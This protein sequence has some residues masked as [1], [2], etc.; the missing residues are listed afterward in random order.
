MPEK[1]GALYDV[2]VDFNKMVD[3][4]N[5][6]VLLQNNFAS[7][8]WHEF[9]TPIVSIKGYAELLK[10]NEN[11]SKEEYDK[12]INIIIEETRRLSNLTQST[13]LISKLDTLNHFEETAP[14]KIN[15][16]IEECVIL[17]DG[18]FQEKNID[19]E[20]SLTPYV[21]SANADTFKNL[22]INL[23][24]NAI[25]YNK[26]NGKIIVKSFIDDDRYVITF[27]DTGIGM[28]KKTLS[29][30]FDKYYQGD[31]S[32]LKKG[33]GLGLPIAKR[34]VELAGGYMFASSEV[35][36]GTTFTIFFP[37]NK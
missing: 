27:E 20:L 18:S 11:L 36:V 33:N 10:N 21:I 7:N 6:T 34:I 23:F 24:T 28:D 26:E 19:V 15:E 13:L 4:L 29:H 3:E 5:S 37:I 16:Q 14:I 25:K 12:Y 31:S 32:H 30:I 22:W 1:Q 9:K 17:L 35:G 8:F 2:I